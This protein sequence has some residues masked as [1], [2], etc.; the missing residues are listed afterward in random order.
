LACAAAGARI[1]AVDISAG[2]A[3]ET[4]HLIAQSGGTA[5]ALA[6]DVTD[7]TVVSAL[8]TKVISAY[9][10]IDCAFNNAGVSQKTKLTADIDIADWDRIFNVNVRGVLLCMQAELHHMANRG[11]GSIVN[12]SSVSGVRSLPGRSAYVASKHAVIGLT[13]NA[14]IE[15]ATQGIRINAVCPGGVFTA[16][17]EASLKTQPEDQRETILAA[18]RSLHPMKRLGLAEEVADA[19]VFLLSSRSSFITGQA[20]GIDGGWMAV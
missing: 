11:R 16:M 17:M 20:L 3:D 8:V 18:S 1:A 9:G 6:G 19:V 15:Y 14:A 2:A 10:A 13:K 4:A 5:I 12:T 7:E